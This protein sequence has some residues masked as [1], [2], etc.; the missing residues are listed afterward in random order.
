M[1]ICFF[2]IHTVHGGVKDT[3]FSTN[4]QHSLSLI[5]QLGTGL[6][7]AD[8]VTVGE[9]LSGGVMQGSTA[10]LGGP[11]AFWEH[12]LGRRIDDLY[13]F[14]PNPVLVPILR[15]AHFVLGIM[16]AYLTGRG[17]WVAAALPLAFATSHVELLMRQL[18]FREEDSK[19]AALARAMN[20]PCKA[21]ILDMANSLMGVD[22]NRCD[23]NPKNF[24]NTLL[25]E[26]LWPTYHLWI[27]SWLDHL[28]EGF[29]EGFGLTITDHNR[30]VGEVP[31]KINNIWGRTGRSSS[32]VVVE[33]QENQRWRMATG[34]AWESPYM[35]GDFA[36]LCFWDQAEAPRTAG[37]LASIDVTKLKSVD[38]F[39]LPRDWFWEPNQEWEDEPWEYA[40]SFT[41]GVMPGTSPEWNDPENIILEANS[42]TH[43]R[44]RKW[45]RV[46]TSKVPDE[47]ALMQD[48]KDDKDDNVYEL[49]LEVEWDSKAH[50]EFKHAALTATLSQV[51]AK[52]N[53]QLI[54]EF[55][56][57]NTSADANLATLQYPGLEK[58]SMSLVKTP[59]IKFKIDALGGNLMNWSLLK[60]VNKTYVED[61]VFNLFPMCFYD[62]TAA[63]RS[64]RQI[65]EQYAR[66]LKS[67]QSVR[68]YSLVS[69]KEARWKHADDFAGSRS[70][71]PTAL[72]GEWHA[73][74]RGRLADR[75]E[76]A[77][78]PLPQEV[79]LWKVATTA[80]VPMTKVG[81]VAFY[82]ESFTLPIMASSQDAVAGT[83][84][85][86]THDSRAV[87]KVVNYLVELR[88]TGAQKSE[89]NILWSLPI[90]LHK[91]SLELDLRSPV[92]LNP[93]MQLPSVT[94]VFCPQNAE[95]SLHTAMRTIPI[96]N[97]ALRG[98]KVGSKLSTYLKKRSEAGG[99]LL[100]KPIS[101][102]K[103]SAKK[104][105]RLK[106]TLCV[107]ENRKE[108]L[109]TRWS[110]RVYANY[111]RTTPNIVNRTFQPVWP[112]DEIIVFSR[113]GFR[114]D[115]LSVCVEVLTSK[116]SG[117]A[118][119]EEEDPKKEKAKAKEETAKDNGKE[120][121]FWNGPEATEAVEWISIS[122]L[123]AVGRWPG[124][125]VPKNKSEKSTDP[126]NK[127]KEEKEEE[128]AVMFMTAKDQINRKLGPHL[129]T[130]APAYHKFCSLMLGFRPETGTISEFF[131]SEVTI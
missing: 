16:A 131:F 14:A 6:K 46:L 79:Q 70:E 119:E 3:K 47:A 114:A 115:R 62:A 25:G 121:P 93:Q 69:V 57:L 10:H 71:K 95:S 80:E 1:C 96:D 89:R 13:S 23:R 78:A 32:K 36:H 106:F 56:R 65:D 97:R 41:R 73:I 39:P 81:S 30:T 29:I 100:I 101:C 111:S 116:E 50:L 4:K 112:E 28:V 60:W 37:V 94:H 48:L 127:E 90:D 63:G 22:R 64:S 43:V 52:L 54:F 24:L 44:R 17:G 68:G 108:A 77:N 103:I 84:E 98:V 18:L 122:S 7:R 12:L 49:Y 11:L 91:Q 38:E 45:T 87:A 128:E 67:L 92:W 9:G 105:V 82:A 117:I 88:H 110:S 83:P 51:Y 21:C 19:A 20:N 8:R 40:F 34:G 99:T 123:V 75:H 130:Q 72:K 2:C 26:T 86:A 107:G 61:L 55:P 109:E 120:S 27:A 35:P 129:V 126:D 42:N 31:I 118:A 124:D 66:A 76:L 15:N 58:L 102:A 74:L 33:I 113:V 125:P 5:Q 59:S 85:A 53:I 104:W